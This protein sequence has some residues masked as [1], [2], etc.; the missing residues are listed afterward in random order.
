MDTFIKSTSDLLEA[1]PAATVLITYSN[2]AK[3]LKTE[4]TKK[5]SN[6]VRFKV[7]DSQLG[8]CI[9]YSTYKT[10]ELSKLLTF[11]GPHGVSMK[12]KID[13]D[14][15][16]DK[17]QKLNVGAAGVMTNAKLEETQ[18]AEAVESNVGT[19][20]P[21]EVTATTSSKKKK[22]KGKKK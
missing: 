11:L 20:A 5:A 14:E 13:D 21:E 2:V 9:K 10:K 15:T 4:D 6:V 17:K 19:P 22:K 18:P 3:K 12:R 7:Y 1:F 16:S 8:N